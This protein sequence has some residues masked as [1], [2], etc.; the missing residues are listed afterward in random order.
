M[1][2][3]FI[4]SLN[5]MTDEDL[6]HESKKKG[7]L[8]FLSENMR[9]IFI[10]LCMLVA[11][12]CMIYVLMST[13]SYAEAEDIYE[14][15]DSEKRLVLAMTADRASLATPDYAACLNLSEEDINHYRDEDDTNPMFKKMYT[16]LYFMTQ[17]YP[18]VYGWITIPGTNINYPI[19]QAEDNDYYLR[20][21]Y[22]GARLL[23][24]SIF[25]DY[26][27]DRDLLENRNLILYGHHMTHRLMFHDLDNYL[28]EEFFN[29]YN[30]MYIYT[31]KGVYTYK[32]MAAFQTTSDFYYIKTSF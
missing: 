16:K 10:T 32:I 7:I 19:M 28:S 29:E 25:A 3:E 26:R 22:S 12:G 14:D 31:L 5:E 21:S 23:A 9:P 8:A 15:I 17:S 1:N 18:D 2:N 27:N 6:G 11:A 4:T 24:G 13:F 20:R 30:T